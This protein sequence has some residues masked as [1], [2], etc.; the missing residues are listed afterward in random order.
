MQA[1]ELFRTADTVSQS[2]SELA[3]RYFFSEQFMF[4]V[5]L[6]MLDTHHGCAFPRRLQLSKPFRTLG[7]LAADRRPFRRPCHHALG[8]QPSS[9]LNPP[10]PGR[11]KGV[12]LSD[13]VF[14]LPV[15]VRYG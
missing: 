1:I 10:R 8:R 15:N 7:I 5:A 3:S 2:I 4:S 13:A 12:V 6:T 14:Q 11:R 9:Q